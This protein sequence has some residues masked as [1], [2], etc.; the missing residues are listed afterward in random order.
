MEQFLGCTCC[1]F[2]DCNVIESRKYDDRIRRRRQCPDCG[3][4]ITTVEITEKQFSALNHAMIQVAKGRNDNSFVIDQLKK[5]V[6][7]LELKP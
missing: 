4:R 3:Q 6:H 1:R 7:Q 5:L 2:S